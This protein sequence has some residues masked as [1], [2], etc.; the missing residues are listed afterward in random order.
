[1]GLFD[2]I[3]YGLG[4]SD[5]KPSGYDERTANTIEKNQGS[6]AAD[7]YRDEKGIGSGAAAGLTFGSTPVGDLASNQVQN[8][9]P[10]ELRSYGPNPSFF[11]DLNK[12]RQ[13]G[14]RAMIADMSGQPLLP[15]GDVTADDIKRYQE[16][17]EF[18]KSKA[19]KNFMGTGLTQQQYA[20][21]QQYGFKRGADGQ[22]SVSSGDRGPAPT[23]GLPAAADSTD[24]N[25]NNAFLRERM[26][27]MREQQ[28]M[29]PPQKPGLPP[30]PRPQM[31]QQLAGIMQLQDRSNISP[32][33]R[34]AAENYY[35]LG[36][37]Q[38]M[39]DEFERG[40]GMIQGQSV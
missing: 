26:A 40:R 24:F 36:G 32:A 14:Y 31:P 22:M 28:G 30:Q 13:I 6:A 17:T 21:G 39:D 23:V 37:R 8:A 29:L 38:M 9:A 1:M 33:M 16:R 27:Q 7:R 34:Y 5:T 18:T 11:G 19:D 35:R 15:F 12:D 25:P 10:T 2:D 3:S 4:I 20:D